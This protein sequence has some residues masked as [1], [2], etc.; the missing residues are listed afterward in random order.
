MPSTPLALLAALPIL[1]ALVLLTGLRWPALRAM[2]LCGLVTA[3]LATFVWKVRAVDVTA[4]VI[5]G[6]IITSS[7]LLILFGALLLTAQLHAA[8]AMARLQSWIGEQSADRRIQALLVAWLF[9]SFIE[10]AAGFGAPAAL[11][12]PILVAIG[13]PALLAVVVALIGDSVAVTFG[14]VGTPLVVG[15]DEALSSHGALWADAVG[16]QA[17]IYD[18]FSGSLMPML[19]V[20]VVTIASEGRQGVRTGLAV[21]PFALVVGL[22][23]T[24]SSALVAHGLG[25]ELPSL[26]GPAVALAAALLMLRFGW[27]VPTR[28]WRLPTDASGDAQPLGAGPTATAASAAQVAQSLGRALT[29][30]AL[31]VALLV[32]TRLPAFGLGP[33]L[34]A[35]AVGWTGILGTSLSSHVRPLHSPGFLFLLVAAMAV[36]LFRMRPAALVESARQA[37]ATTAR[38]AGALFFAVATVR[39]FI[40]SGANAHDVPAM[41]LVLARVAAQAGGELWPWFAPWIGALGSFIAGSATFSNMLFAPMQH[42]VSVSEALEPTKVLALQAMGASAGNMVC[43]HNVVAATAVVKLRSAE[44]DVIRGTSLPMLAYLLLLGLVGSF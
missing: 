5:E 36:P 35:V 11:T 30:Y 31:L 43:V 15:I 17:S 21:A 22:V 10:G 26:V 34:R 4:A 39:I 29:P 37:G 38:A 16:R 1:T 32:V 23:H 44:G 19:L 3:G 9:G 2:P 42:A 13:F 6:A 33:H 8:G 20:F 24:S 12:A 40:H 18:I 41:P 25:P 28:T 14:A 7:I 27:L